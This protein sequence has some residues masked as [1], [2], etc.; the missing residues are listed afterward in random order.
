MSASQVVVRSP[1][2]L[3]PQAAELAPASD[4]S[5]PIT[6]ARVS[7]S[8]APSP[9][10]HATSLTAALTPLINSA[11]YRSTSVGAQHEAQVACTSPTTFCSPSPHERREAAVPV[12][13]S[14]LMSIHTAELLSSA[15]G[16][17]SRGE[18][19]ERVQGS[20]RPG[21]ARPHRGSL[22]N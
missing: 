17:R 3:P 2:S 1:V 5:A 11:R 8:A 20:L 15:T 10:Q 22:V 18:R 9:K 7:R 6:L 14:E 12:S 19:R 13:S 4:A 16:S 21:Q